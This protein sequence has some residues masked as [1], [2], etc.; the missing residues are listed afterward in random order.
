MRKS[1][2]RVTPIRPTKSAPDPQPLG[3]GLHAGVVQCAVGQK[4]RVRMFDGTVLDAGLGPVVQAALL[5]QCAA[6]GR[7]VILSDLGLG[8]VVLGALQ[9]APQVAPDA[10][11]HLD[12]RVERLTLEG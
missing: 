12:I 1:T 2:A 9:T 8:P 11:G 5:H 4:W 6:D 10:E 7:L 3:S